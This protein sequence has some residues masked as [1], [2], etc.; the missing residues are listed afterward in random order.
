MVSSRRS[1]P[2]QALAG[3]LG[4]SRRVGC[5]QAGS[6][7]VMA[8]VA[9]TAESTQQGEP[10]QRENAEERPRLTVSDVSAELR[11]VIH[12]NGERRDLSRQSE[13]AAAAE[14][15]DDFS[16]DLVFREEASGFELWLGSLDDALSLESLKRHNINAFLNIAHEECERECAACREMAAG[17]RGRRRRC[18]ARGPSVA[19]EAHDGFGTLGRDQIRSIALF[20]M[21]WYSEMLDSDV[22]YCGIAAED[23]AGYAIGQHFDEAADFLSKCRAEGR[24]VMVHC[25]MGINRSATALVAFLC[26]Q[27]QMSL[28][29]AVN[30]ASRE[31]G[32]I[33]SNETFLRQ[34]VERFGDCEPDREEQKSELDASQ[35]LAESGRCRTWPVMKQL[36]TTA[37]EP[38][39]ESDESLPEAPRQIVCVGGTP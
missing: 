18:H 27:L 36:S 32:Y 5:L 30:I 38:E 10:V 4:G 37:E 21:N 24:K 28:Q 1:R 3:L 13:R 34:L 17:G 31:R 11:K 25:I 19:D 39:D 6:C 29:E 12:A 9:N 26:R 33:L 35:N 14:R 15:Q 23:E 2:G 8:S 16:A 7:P 22:A 20:D